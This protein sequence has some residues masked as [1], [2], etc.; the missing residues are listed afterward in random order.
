[1]D[2]SGYRGHGLVNSFYKGDQ[3]IGTLDSPPFTIARRYINFLIGGGKNGTDTAINL[4]VEGK[5]VRTATGPNDKPGGSERLDWQTWDVSEL[6]GKTARIQIVDRATGGWGHINVDDIT[7]SDRREQEEVSAAELY[8]ETYRPQFHFTPRANWTNDPNGLVYYAGEYH[9]FFQHNPT[10]IN[11]GNMTWGHAVSPDLVH[12]K[13]LDNAIEPDKLGTIFSG[14]AVV[15]WENTAG[16]QKGPEKTLVAIYTA[17]GGTNPESKGVPFTQCL[18]YSSDRGRTW[19]KYAGNPVLAHIAAENRDPKVVWHAP[20]RRWIMALFLDGNEYALFSSPDLKQWTR[21]QSITMKDCGECP[22][23][24]EIPVEGGRGEKKWVL[25]AANGHYLIGAFDGQR[26]TPEAG[27]LVPD[28]G[29]N[30]Y[31]VQS[32]SDIPASDGRRIQIAWMNG[33]S[34]PQMPFNQ[35][36]S[37]PCTLELRHTDEGL[38]LYRWPVRE[39]ERLYGSEKPVQM[40]GRALGAEPLPVPGASSDLWDVQAEFEVGKAS[41]V[42]LRLRGEAVT[43]IAKDGKLRALGREAPLKPERGRIRIRALVD[44]TS[45]EVFGNG[46]RVSLTSC[47]LPQQRDRSIEV[48]ATGGPA[49]LVS[50]TARPL[51]SAWAQP[52]NSSR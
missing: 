2:V 30:Y 51:H 28:Y 6:E 35:Q 40:R 20:T 50:L 10:G 13:Q 48:F 1:M 47:F 4:L 16:F 3:S 18:A 29:A 15:D 52:T 9:L 5:A 43:Y 19:T 27:P 8:N 26:F 37:F 14:S 36:M 25:T 49:R 23:F 42:G 44:R 33:G 45:L 32:Y 38:R 31:A 21:L 39:I 17:A 24:F 34:Y 41:E 22:D 7:Q 46:G 11:W 12:W